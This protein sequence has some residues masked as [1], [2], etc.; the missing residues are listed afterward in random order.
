MP[1]Q[2]GCHSV[3]HAEGFLLL[4]ELA[5]VQG[6]ISKNPSS[7]ELISVFV[8]KNS[9]QNTCN[10]FS[11]GTEVGGSCFR[12]SFCLYATSLWSVFS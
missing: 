8:C 5:V 9:E 4:G 7:A 11:A 2:V 3:D 1:R 10:S 6:S 12:S